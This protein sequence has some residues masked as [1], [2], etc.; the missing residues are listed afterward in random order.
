MS[1]FYRLN[2]AEKKARLR[3]EAKQWQRDFAKHSYS[4]GEIADR[5]T[6]FE[7]EGRKYGLTREFRNEGII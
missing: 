4:Y 5:Q 7:R 3:N 1:D 6:Y 2:Y